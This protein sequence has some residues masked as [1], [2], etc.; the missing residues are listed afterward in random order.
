M[1]YY[2]CFYKGKRYEVLA[3]TLYEAQKICS[4]QNNIRKVS[5]I[6]VAL[7]EKNHIPVVTLP[8][9]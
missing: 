1:Y 2:I 5:D 8:L 7:A 9:I 6:N 3:N 4:R